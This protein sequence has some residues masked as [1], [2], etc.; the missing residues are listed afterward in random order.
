MESL[1]QQYGDDQK[2]DHQLL[3]L[4]RN[5]AKNL[6]QQHQFSLIQNQFKQWLQQRSEQHQLQT[7]CNALAQQSAQSKIQVDLQEQQYQTH[8]LERENLQRM[9]QQQRLLHAENIEKLREQLIDGEACLVCGSLHHPFKTDL[10]ALSSELVN[11]QEQQEQQAIQI[12]QDSFNAWQKSQQLH[13]QQTASLSE[14][15]KRLDDLNIQH[16]QHE[17]A[18]YQSFK[19]AQIQIDL[20]QQSERD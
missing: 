6:E 10:S 8:K 3:E 4:R 13:T 12:E 15:Q 7:T 2:I 5:Q 16:Q 9:L 11:L 1:Q 20:T 18:L 19:N 17:Q 14:Q